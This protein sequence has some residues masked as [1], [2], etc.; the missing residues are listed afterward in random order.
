MTNM[1]ETDTKADLRDSRNQQ[2]RIRPNA[3]EKELANSRKT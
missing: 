1:N 3:K 2:F